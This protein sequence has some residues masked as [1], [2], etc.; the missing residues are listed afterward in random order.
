MR[1]ITVS[2]FWTLRDPFFVSGTGPVVLFMYGFIK[3]DSPTVF[4][5]LEAGAILAGCVWYWRNA[6]RYPAMGVVLA[7]L[8][9]FFAWRS[10]WIYFYYVDVILLATVMINEYGF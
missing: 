9:L 5:V 6:G 10:S 3:I 8:P 2:H 1:Y 7:A 4:L